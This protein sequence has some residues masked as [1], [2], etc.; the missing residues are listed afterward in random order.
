[1]FTVRDCVSETTTTAGS[2]DFI[3]AARP[4]FV[5]FGDALDG[6]P[7]LFVYEAH[8]TNGAGERTGDFETGIGQFFIDGG[9][10]KIRRVRKLSGSDYPNM[11]PID[12]A[13]GSKTVSMVVAAS[14]VGGLRLGQDQ[15]GSLPGIL[16]VRSDGNDANTGLENTAGGAF[17][18][19]SHALNVALGFYIDAEIH[20][21]SGSFGGAWAS[22]VSGTVS[23]IGSGSGSTTIDGVLAQAGQHISVTG[24]RIETIN[25]T[26]LD[27]TGTGAS[28]LASEIEFGA[29]NYAHARAIDGGTIELADYTVSGGASGGSHLRAERFG[30]ILCTGTATL[31]DD[32]TLAGSWVDCQSGL[33]LVDYDGGSIDLNGFTVTGKRYELHAGSVCNT[34]GGGASFL[35][36]SSAGT[37]DSGGI[38]L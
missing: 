37:V 9:V 6:S 35:P 25:G 23:I 20:V 38:Y 33:G 13:A 18:T 4:G 31:T 2:G 14:Q 17:A 22:G 8:A 11:A 7:H 34:H 36:G 26:G 1:M 29:C 3:L 27:C 24:C 32:V 10:H 15:G 16:Y 5:R 21:G 12:F 28:M 19:L 30:K